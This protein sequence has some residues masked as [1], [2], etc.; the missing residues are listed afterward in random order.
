MTDARENPAPAVSEFYDRLAPDYDAMTGFEKRFVL[1][2]PFF[3]LL[4]EKFGIRTAL[5]AGSG[6][7]FH[8]L[9]LA[10][11]GV[12]VTAVDVSQEMMERLAAHARTMDLRVHPVIAAFQDLRKTVAGPFDALFCLGNSLPHLLTGEDLRRTLENFHAV[13]RP[14]GMLLVQ[15]LNYDRIM[16]SRTRVQSVRESGGTTFVRMYDYEQAGGLILFNLLRLENNAGE[17]A[18]TLQSVPLRP[19]RAAGLSEALEQSGFTDIRRFGGISMD[20]YDAASSRDLVV[21]ASRKEEG[22]NRPP[23]TIKEHA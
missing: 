18:Q 12:E 14:G 5:D 9:L 15:L 13:L 10:Q 17:A 3:R 22:K 19:L 6:T 1:E 7:G 8:A 23:S 4:V 11:L 2:R 20:A 16:S 21:L